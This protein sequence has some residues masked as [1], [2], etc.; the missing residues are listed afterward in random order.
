MFFFKSVNE[1]ELTVSLPDKALLM[2]R[3]NSGKVLG[4]LYVGQVQL[5]YCL[6]L[7]TVRTKCEASEHCALTRK[8]LEACAARVGSRSHTEEECTEELP[9]CTGPL[10]KCNIC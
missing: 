10:C 5:M 2:A 9:T 7:Y 1:A 3:C 4:Q 6:V 8:R